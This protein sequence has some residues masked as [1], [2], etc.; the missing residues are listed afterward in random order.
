MIVSRIACRATIA[1]PFVL[2]AIVLTACGGTARIAAPIMPTTVI[3]ETS[4]SASLAFDAT[5]PISGLPDKH[6]MALIDNVY[7]RYRPDG[8]TIAIRFIG[9]TPYVPGQACTF[10]YDAEAQEFTDKVLVTVHL[11]T[12][13]S[14]LVGCPANQMELTEVQVVLAEP[15]GSRTLLANDWY[16]P[17]QIP[18]AGTPGE[19][20][21]Q[22]LLDWFNFVDGADPSR[23][24]AG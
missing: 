1:T 22:P 5:V 14:D 7:T 2:T 3:E 17:F 23:P 13:A 8:N 12:P 4:T 18:I 11:W 24:V 19:P 15:L 6:Y 20:G 21:Q 10:R 9:G 16:G